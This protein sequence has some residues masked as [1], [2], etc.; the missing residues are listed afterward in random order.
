M[1]VGSLLL[2][3]LTAD[4]ADPFKIYL[5]IIVMDPYCSFISYNYLPALKN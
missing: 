5:M 4:S 1:F 3:T 2:V